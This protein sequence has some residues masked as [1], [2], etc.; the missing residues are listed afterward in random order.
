M[1]KTKYHKPFANLC[2][3]NVT[4]L[5]IDLVVTNTLTTMT[6]YHKLLQTIE[7]LQNE[8]KNVKVTILPSTITRKRK[9][10]L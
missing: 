9:Q 7:Q 5:Q 1:W 3:L 4:H 10:L 2:L 6:S 8:G